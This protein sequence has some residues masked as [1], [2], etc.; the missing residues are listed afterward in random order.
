MTRFALGILTGLAAAWTA[1]AIWGRIPL[2]GPIEVA[3]RREA[4]DDQTH[5]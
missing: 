2:L 5:G 1:L 3:R 4:C